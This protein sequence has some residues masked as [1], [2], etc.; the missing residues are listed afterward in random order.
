M[1]NYY[2]A[3]L[4]KEFSDQVE[5]LK[6]LAR[7][8]PF[9]E[10]TSTYGVSGNTFRAFTGYKLPPSKVY[11]EWASKQTR[12]IFSNPSIYFNSQLEFDEWHNN[13][14]ESLKNYWLERQGKELSFA[15]TY[16]AIDLF[17]KWLCSNSNC[18]EKLSNSF[19]QYGYC[20][21]DS[22]ILHKLNLC[23]SG[24]LPIRK[25]TMGDITNKYTYDFC[26]SLIKDFTEY[27]GG[28]RLLFD[29]YAWKSGGVNDI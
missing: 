19:L 27:Y 13:K 10:K 2:N 16:K 7:K 15:H 18:S 11:R 21:L 5:T 25:P 26:Q 29:Y 1:K 4:G 20:A 12:L 17:V 23:L 14:F 22:Q 6:N 9:D 3:E 28:T 8:E 24:A